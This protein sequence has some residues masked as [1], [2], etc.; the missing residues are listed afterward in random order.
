MKNRSIHKPKT[1]LV[2]IVLLVIFILSFLSIDFSEMIFS[3]EFVEPIIDGMLNPEWEFINT[4]G[5]EDLSS[6]LVT[7]ITIGFLG[8]LIGAVFAL[9]LS[10]LAAKNLWDE[11]SVVPKIGK[12]FFDILRSF[13]ELVYAIVFV[14]VVGPGPFAGALAIG[15]SQIGMLGKLFA[16]DMEALPRDSVE[17]MEA[18]GANFWQTMVYARLPILNPSYFS[19]ILNHFEIAVRS[20]AVLGLVGAGGIGAPL[21]FAI[22][23]RRW[24]R[25]S[26]ILLGIIILVFLIDA[27]TGYIRKRLN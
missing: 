24:P 18:V 23:A 3:W 20:A 1:Y 11:N 21:V 7:T 26:I 5:S 2:L 14:R 13:P 27:L 6:L 9:P 12:F 17:S 10:F 4:G 25:V 8:T 15:V 16:E 19:Y 22:Q